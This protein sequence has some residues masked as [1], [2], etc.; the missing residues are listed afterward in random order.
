MDAEGLAVR[1]RR[2]GEVDMKPRG[3]LPPAHGA[4]AATRA[5]RDFRRDWRGWSA[6][7]RIWAAALGSFSVLVVT[8]VI[9]AA[10]AR[11]F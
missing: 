4:S 11:L 8:T 7:E 1:V 2:G 6:A 5:L 3:R 10:D 9:V